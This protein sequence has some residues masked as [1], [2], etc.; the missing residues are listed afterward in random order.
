MWSNNIA[1]TSYTFEILA[2]WPLIDPG[3]P[4]SFMFYHKGQAGCS[5]DNSTSA[6]VEVNTSDLPGGV[7]DGP[8]LNPRP[9]AYYCS[10]GTVLQIR[11]SNDQEMLPRPIDVTES[12]TII[13][14]PHRLHDQKQLWAE[15]TGCSPDLKS[16]PTSVFLYP[17]PSL[18]EPKI[19]DDS[20]PH[21]LDTTVQGI[22]LV[23]GARA[24]LVVN[25]DRRTKSGRPWPQEVD[26]FYPDQTIPL[27]APLRMDTPWASSSISATLQ[28]PV[29][30]P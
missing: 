3:G 29:T 26:V 25:G 5:A 24:Y 23:P 13:R 19:L 15:Q 2:R 14:L 12:P 30:P 11:D 7:P 17:N 22:D 1:G 10:N 20:P 28:I 8:I 21:V 18:P 6:P 9:T 4:V 16:D 27:N